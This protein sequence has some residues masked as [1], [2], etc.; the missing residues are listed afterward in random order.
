MVYLVY[1]L[2][3][4][5]NGKSYIGSTQ[6]F[7]RRY[8]R[9]LH[10]LENKQHHNQ[11][12]QEDYNLGHRFK[13]TKIV[14][15]SRQEAYVLEDKLIKE[16]INSGNLYNI[17]S[18]SIGGDNLTFNPNRLKIID[19]IK[20]TLASRINNLTTEE[21][22]VKFGRSGSSNGMYGKTHS[23]ETK[24][25]LSEINKGRIPINKGIPMSEADKVKLKESLRDRNYNGE[26]NPF[27]NRRHNAEAKRKIGLASSL[28]AKRRKVMIGDLVYDS[29]NDAALAVGVTGPTVIYRIK[30]SKYTNYSYLNAQRLEKAAKD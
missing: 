10:D 19:K 25:R 18:S 29:V 16:N 1:I 12:L 27:H 7:S 6:D 9:H 14:L 17:G 3:N 21:R 8:K 5:T 4:K 13:V 2:T 20:K 26:N 24:Q 23:D 28:R 22:K 15:D 11:M 30:S